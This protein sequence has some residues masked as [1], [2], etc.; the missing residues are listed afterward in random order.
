MK[1]RVFEIPR[2][3][4]SREDDA[5]SSSFNAGESDKAFTFWVAPTDL[6]GRED[7]LGTIADDM[8]GQTAAARPVMLGVSGLYWFALRDSAN[9]T[10]LTIW[11]VAMCIAVV[12]WTVLWISRNK[13]RNA[14]SERRWMLL[15]TIAA[16]YSGCAWSGVFLTISDWKTLELLVPAWMLIL[17][18]VSSC[19]ASMGAHL[20][21]FM[22]YTLPPVILGTVLL[23]TRA[24]ES[25]QWLSIA[26]VAYYMLLIEFT[27]RTN[28]DFLERL[29]L[30]RQNEELL[31][32]VRGEVTE[33][34][35]IIDV[36]TKELR[37]T[38]ARLEEQAEERALLDR[39]ARRRLELL[40][41]VVDSTEDIIFY[42]DYSTGEGVY[43]GGNLSFCRF[44]GIANEEVAGK[45]DV[46]FF[47][48]TRAMEQNAED[49]AV[50]ELGS[51]VTERW[52]RGPEGR[53]IL[54][55]TLKSPYKDE[56]GAISGIVGVARDITQQKR[57]EVTLRR[58]RRSL[59]RLAH[60][61]PLTGLPNR[62]HLTKT[63][64]RIIDDGENGET[65]LALL[66]IDLDHFKDI[67]DSLGHSVGD[68]VLRAV[69]ERLGQCVRQGDI[70][71]RLGG[72]EFTVLLPGLRD[73]NAAAEVS[74]KIITAFQAPLRLEG[75]ELTLT[76]SIG[77]SHYP[78]DGDTT[79]ALLKN[80]DA[81]MYQ[82]KRLGRNNFKH[83]TSDLTENASERIALENDLHNAISRHELFME[84]QPQVDMR[85]GQ[86]IGAEALMR[87][88]HGTRG[89][90]PPSEFIH[91]AE[92]T[93]SI[94]KLG[95]WALS[96]V[97]EDML[98][99]TKS[100]MTG[101][102]FAVNVSGRQLMDDQFFDR[103]SALVE[104]FDHILGEGRNV[105]E[106]EL[107]ESVLVLETERVEKMMQQFRDIDVNI[108]VD[109][110]GTGYSSLSYLKRYPISRLKIDSSFVQDI[111]TDP[112]DRAIAKTVIGLAHSLDMSVIAEGVE[113]EPQRRLLLE[114]GCPLGQGYLFARPLGPESLLD[115]FK[116]HQIGEPL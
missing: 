101:M 94:S 67:N 13:Y 5:E 2:F 33:R 18:V 37:S 88:R 98:T 75:R 70:I 23:V 8:Y 10:A 29:L 61:D 20:T 55:S 21:S 115:F 44:L 40:N 82:A 91:V 42:K 71:A 84:Y 76:P 95:F 99:M 97:F 43:L 86:M 28:R 9:Y 96:T 63:L 17:G 80:A 45:R 103:V 56:T 83:Y 48:E 74:R 58:Q 26:M 102:T 41:S 50:M 104:K 47:D 6:R 7:V 57:A 4:R 107:T 54:L 69:A 38:N 32:Q 36:R 60:H 110:F 87:W 92:K 46:D 3:L 34:E 31:E 62:L 81:A 51:K 27:R 22:L 49:Q 11:L 111:D 90:V 52:V 78:I 79:E 65:H 24:A 93:G 66:F 64:D 100:G 109:D 68:Q 85:T 30:S 19:S 113:T 116:Q 35:E 53:R 1:K 15:Y 112:N 39:Q 77:V 114:D 105:L 73:P 108:A 12:F 25:L 59:Q 14:F 89:L 72:D 16:A 106:L